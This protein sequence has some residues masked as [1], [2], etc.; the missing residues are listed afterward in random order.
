MRK[1]DPR[2]PSPTPLVFL[3]AALAG[4]AL[5]ALSLLVAALLPWGF[6]ALFTDAAAGWCAVAILLGLWASTRLA[7]WQV[8]VCGAVALLSA[9]VCY[10][11]VATAL[12]G[13]PGALLDPAGWLLPAWLWL[14]AACAAGP[15]L[16][17]AGA[18]IGHERRALRMTGLGLLGGVFLADALLPV[19]DWVHFRIVSPEVSLPLS[20]V[21]MFVQSAFYALLGVVLVLVL[22]RGPGDRPRALAAMVP[23]GL[24]W[25]VGVWGAQKVMFLSGMGYLG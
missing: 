23:A 22:A 21:P 3:L 4:P 18:W 24:L 7:P 5:G 9:V 20:P 13:G 6:G 15:V 11:G 8:P 16:T 19:L 14:L 1:V 25:Y 12:T 17:T 2:P 10:Y